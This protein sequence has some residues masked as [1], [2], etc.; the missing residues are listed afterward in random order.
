MFDCDQSYTQM[1]LLCALIALWL[2]EKSF[3]PIL[4]GSIGGE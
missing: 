2:F 3:L 1:A 4:A